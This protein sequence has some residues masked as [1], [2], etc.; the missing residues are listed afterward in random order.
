MSYFEEPDWPVYC[1]CRYDPVND[2][3][4]REDCVLHF[5]L[6]EL[7]LVEERPAQ[8]FELESPPVPRKPTAVARRDDEEENAA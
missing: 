4:D 5:D 2:T 7:P 1:E 6:D 3:M 8:E